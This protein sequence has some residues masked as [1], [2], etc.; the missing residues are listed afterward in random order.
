MAVFRNHG[1]QIYMRTARLDAESVR[2]LLE[3]F[4]RERAWSLFDELQAAVD[5]VEL[6]VAT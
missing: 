3:I 5:G 2:V 4:Q 6:E 1:G